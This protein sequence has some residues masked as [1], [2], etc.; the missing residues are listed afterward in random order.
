MSK[1][2]DL[3]E[4][5]GIVVK[6]SHSDWA[7]PVFLVPK[8]NGDY[9]LCIDFKNTLNPALKTDIS[10]LPT[11]E[12][13]FSALNGGAI[14]CVI[15]LTESY[16][17]LR[18]NAN[19]QKYLTINTHKGLYQFTRLVY[20]VSSAPT[21]FQMFMETLLQ[22]I[23]KTAVFLDDILIQGSD[24]AECLA[25]VEKVLAR[26]NAHNLHIQPAKCKW[27]QEKVEYLGHV[28]SKNGR[29]PSPTL[30]KAIVDAPVP[31]KGRELRSFLGLL[32]F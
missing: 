15:D 7:S 5:E 21:L 13:I 3:W 14:F 20:G 9:R 16:T 19:S 4:R 6:V 23:P 26:L 28:I 2:L 10:P 29:S 8:E 1:K 24:Y 30:C 17:Q 32:N 11:L 27:L 25:N 22:G 18:V 12:N 31:T